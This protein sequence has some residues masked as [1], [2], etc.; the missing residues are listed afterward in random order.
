MPHAGEYKPQIIIDFRNGGH[1]GAGIAGRDLLLD[2]D[3]GRNT[4]YHIHVRLAHTPEKLTGIGRKALREAPLTLREEGVKDKGRLAGAG[5]PGHHDKLP[6]R[7]FECQILKI[8][9]SG[10]FD[11]DISFHLIF[12]PPPRS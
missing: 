6:S 5:N 4:V 9:D 8:V 1:G 2:G 11:C 3:G 10:T 12:L 7:Y